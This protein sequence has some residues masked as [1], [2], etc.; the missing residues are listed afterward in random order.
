MEGFLQPAAA[1]IEMNVE[2]HSV[3]RNIHDKVYSNKLG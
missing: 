2:G 1:V 3:V